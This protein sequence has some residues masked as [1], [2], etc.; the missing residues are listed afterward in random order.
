[1]C[2]FGIFGELHVEV[3]D[4]QHDNFEAQFS[5]RYRQEN[6]EKSFE[7]EPNFSI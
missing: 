7:T 4:L 6:I 1:M 3:S 2:N 5:K